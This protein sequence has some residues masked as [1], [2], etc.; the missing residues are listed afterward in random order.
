MS[1][2]RL[3]CI[4]H[5]KT[6]ASKA[7]TISLRRSF[8]KSSRSL[9]SII[10][11]STPSQHLYRRIREA[12]TVKFQRSRYLPRKSDALR[13]ISEVHLFPM[14]W[15]KLLKRQRNHL[16]LCARIVMLVQ[17]EGSSKRSMEKNQ[18]IAIRDL[19][20]KAKQP[21][22]PHSLP[23]KRTGTPARL[24]PKGRKVVRWYFAKVPRKA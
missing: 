6:E 8:S 13:I 15:Y 7:K 16:F 21:I 23:F 5:S 18:I 22:N 1:Q 12:A 4:P 20:V 19:R 14:G 11:P 2:N 24:R 10:T 9:T 17:E 3:R